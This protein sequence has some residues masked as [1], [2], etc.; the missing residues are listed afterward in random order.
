[1]DTSMSARM[2]EQAEESRHLKTM[3]AEKRMGSL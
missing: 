1:M 2:M 3:Y